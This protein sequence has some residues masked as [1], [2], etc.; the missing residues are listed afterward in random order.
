MVRVN[1]SIIYMD[2]ISKW[3][4]KTQRGYS[5]SCYFVNNIDVGSH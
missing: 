2:F 5:V 3:D 1:F 4:G